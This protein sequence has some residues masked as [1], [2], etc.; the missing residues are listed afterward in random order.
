MI[1]IAIVSVHCA[2]IALNTMVFVPV[3]VGENV[4]FVAVLKRVPL[5]SH[6][7]DNPLLLVF[8]K[9]I[10][11]PTDIVVG[12]YVKLL[13]TLQKGVEQTD[14]V[15]TVLGFAINDVVLL[16]VVVALK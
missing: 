5:F 10:E 1:G 2:P 12:L 11:L 9:F 13:F 7:Y 16:A 14:V 4:G 15:V 6:S 8:V 3:D